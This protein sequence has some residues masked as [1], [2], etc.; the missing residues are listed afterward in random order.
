MIYFEVT[1]TG[2]A[3]HHSGMMRVSARLREELDGAI[4]PVTWDSR[5]H[6]WRTVD[7]RRAVALAAPDWL[8]TTELFSEAERPGFWSFLRSGSGRRAAVF[9]DAIPLRHP[10]ITWPQSVARHPEY[11]KMLAAFDRVW[12]ISEAS[13]RDLEEFWRWQGAEPRASVGT[14]ML[15]ADFDRSPRAVS[16][17]PPP[18][19]RLLLSV[20]ILEPRKN[21]ALLLD[22]AE[23][24]WREGLDF[25]LHLAGR[26]NPHFGKPL[27]ARIKARCRAEPRLRWLK[28]APDILVNGLYARARATV[29]PTLAEGCGL[30]VLES[31]W[32]GVP[33]VCG[34]LPVLREATEGGGCFSVPVNE[35][36][37]WTA[38]LRTI[39]TDDA[40]W[41]RLAAAAAVRPLPTWA[42]TAAKLRAGL[43]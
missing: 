19:S 39:L 8:L 16:G 43:A 36:A 35:P 12:A 2:R 28:A 37:A 41:G 18:A 1:K 34:D 24:L 27:A 14:I 25:E 22:T 6:G 17:L 26:V 7:R 13:R 5:R 33:C 29:F 11:M 40:E 32:K 4:T 23:T 21:Q 10:H 20:G 15:G 30:P 9:Y 31:L 42:E 3:R 38:A